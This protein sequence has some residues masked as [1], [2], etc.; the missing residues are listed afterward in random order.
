MANSKGRN[1]CGQSVIFHVN[2][3]TLGNQHFKDDSEMKFSIGSTMQIKY[4]CYDNTPK[5]IT[6][7]IKLRIYI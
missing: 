7:K 2:M 5:E 6:P 1:S 4:L 3:R